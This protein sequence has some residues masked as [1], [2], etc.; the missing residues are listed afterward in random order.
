MQDAEFKTQFVKRYSELLEG[1]LSYEQTSKQLNQLK[2]EMEPYMQA[3]FTAWPDSRYTY[4][5]WE[6]EVA[7]VDAYLKT[8]PY[9]AKG[10]LQQLA[11]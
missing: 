8:R 9:F 6:E 10:H 4:T 7:N 11:N 3:H 1:Q 5:I 2:K